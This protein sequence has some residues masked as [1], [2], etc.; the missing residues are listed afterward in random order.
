MRD[1]PNPTNN[2]HAAHVDRLLASYRKWTGKSLVFPS[3]DEGKSVSEA[4]Y[5]APS[6]LLSHGTEADP[7]FNYANL[8]GQRIFEMTWAE[9]MTTPSR[10]SAEPLV[11]EERM[12]LFDRVAQ[13]GFIDDYRGVRVSK[14]GRRFYIDQATVWTVLDGDEKLAGQAAVFSHWN[15]L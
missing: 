6:V 9:F 10:F 8:T 11:R 3:V 5:A 12:R 1:Q 4:I 7:V 14:S 2:F 15:Y 13:Y